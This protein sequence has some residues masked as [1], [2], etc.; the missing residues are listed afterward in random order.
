M[1]VKTYTTEDYTIQGVL[2]IIKGM[3]G[4]DCGSNSCLFADNKTGMRT[5]GS[6]TCLDNRLPQLVK[7]GIIKIIMANKGNI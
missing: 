5:N 3:T 2:E 1:E 4:K 6:C 7:N